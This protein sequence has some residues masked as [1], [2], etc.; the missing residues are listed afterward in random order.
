MPYTLRFVIPDASSRV[1]LVPDGSGWALPRVPSDE[2]EIVV[3]VA[4][5]FHDLAGQDVF[6]LRDVRFGPMPPP[7]DAIV[8]LT[9]T[10]REPRPAQGRW[11]AREELADLPFAEPHDRAALQA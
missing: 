10:V 9:E 5:A 1:L 3:D 4:P 6:V 7:D 11:C 2:P 8:Y